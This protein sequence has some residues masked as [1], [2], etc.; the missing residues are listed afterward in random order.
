MLVD[1]GVYLQPAW[2]SQLFW[3]PSEEPGG[4]KIIVYPT[5]LL[6]VYGT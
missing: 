5:D 6:C 1:Y 2:Q 4:D 3:E